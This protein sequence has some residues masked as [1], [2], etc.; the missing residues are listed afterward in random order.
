MD[1]R[2]LWIKGLVQIKIV[3]INLDFID[4]LNASLQRK[5]TV[6]SI[7][8]FA[9]RAAYANFRCGV[10]LLKVET[11]RY[12]G[13]PLEAIICPFCPNRIEDEQHVILHCPA[14]DSLRQ[15]LFRKASNLCEGFCRN[16]DIEKIIVLLS[17]KSL[18][19]IVAKTC[20]LILRKRN[21]QLYIY[22]TLYYFINI[23]A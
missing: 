9:H 19:R 11:G 12:L 23:F 18:V 3:R 1:G 10:A 6:S 22:I 7:C 21:T 5:S 2:C 13:Q 16:D 20:F 15:H 14:Y 4:C 17:T 8:L